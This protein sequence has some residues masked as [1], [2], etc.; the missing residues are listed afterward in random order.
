MK[1][2]CDI[3]K[4]LMIIYNEE[5]SGDT[6]RLVEEHLETCEECREYYRQINESLDSINDIKVIETDTKEKNKAVKKSFSKIRRNS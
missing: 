6:K 4:D 3:I 5:V 1:I 2:T